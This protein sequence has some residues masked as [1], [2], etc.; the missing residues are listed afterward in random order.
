MEGSAKNVYHVKWL[1]GRNEA[2]RI[3]HSV[4]C[5]AYVSTVSLLL[6][7]LAYCHHHHHPHHIISGAQDEVAVFAKRRTGPGSETSGVL[8]RQ[9]CSIQQAN[10]KDVRER[11]NF[12]SLSAHMIVREGPKD[13][14]QRSAKLSHQKTPANPNTGQ[15]G[16]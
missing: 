15:A 4:H 5:L 3:E 14:R 2:K 6:L 11:G 16:K 7:L 13:I 10:G 9:A 12:R 1:S 8:Q